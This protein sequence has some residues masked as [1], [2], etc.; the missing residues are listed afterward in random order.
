MGFSERELAD[1]IKNHFNKW[2]IARSDQ[3]SL[4][5]SLQTL[6]AL[7]PD[8]L[9]DKAFTSVNLCCENFFISH[10]KTTILIRKKNTYLCQSKQNMS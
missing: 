5:F 6:T 8:A 1:K 4:Y 2:E 3:P 7:S 9:D 10:N